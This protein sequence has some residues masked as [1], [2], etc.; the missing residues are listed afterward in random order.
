MLRNDTKLRLLPGVSMDPMERVHNAITFER[1]DEV[2][3]IPLA[4]LW[5]GRF[6]GIPLGELIRSGEK[7]YEAQIKA[8]ER[9]GYDALFGYSDPLYVPESLGCELRILKTGLQT[10]PISVKTVEDIDRL[11]VPDPRK[12]GRIPAVLKA[13]S[14]LSK[15]SNGKIPVIPGFEGPLT[16][17]VRTLDADFLMRKV[18]KDR[19]FVLKLLDKITDILIQVGIALREE[20]ADF[21]FLPDPVT[22]S[23]M[24]S[25]RIA[26]EIEFPCLERLIR[27]VKMPCILHICG[28]S[29]Q[30]LEMM[31]RTGAAVIS[32]DQCMH[33]PKVRGTVGWNVAIGGNIDPINVMQFGT[34]DD[35]RSEVNRLLSENGNRRYVVMTGCSIPPDIPLEN[36]LAAVQAVRG[37]RFG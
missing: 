29:T 12:H 8:F 37:F 36:L 24:V 9:V 11:P 7:I 27:S 33:L 28:D 19:P 25:P 13:V 5:I 4:S 32:L 18:L 20:G 22:S 35:V 2:P 23:D 26:N 15:Y 21:L 6:S 16:A 31:A 10:V 1:A 14:L 34:P 3:V 17:A 30:I